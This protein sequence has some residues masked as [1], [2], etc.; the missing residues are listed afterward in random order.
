MSVPGPAAERPQ[1]TRRTL[2][3]AERTLLAWVRTGLAFG[4]VALAVGKI[5]PEVSD[6]SNEWAYAAIGAGYALLGVLVIVYGLVRRNELDDAISEGGY[7][8]VHRAPHHDRARRQRGPRPGDRRRHPL[9]LTRARSC[10]AGIRSRAMTDGSTD[11][12]RARLDALAREVDA[13]EGDVRAAA[14]RL[15]AGIDRLRGSLEELASAPA[16][17]GHEPGADVDGARLTALD[18]VLRGTLARRGGLDPRREVPRCR[19]GPAV[20][21]GLEGLHGV[22]TCPAR[23]RFV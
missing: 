23:R 5:V 2:L 10:G 9:R 22:E 11:E 17:A 7:A 3:A 21:R 20:R 13:L 1:G 6:S 14:E 18:L 8:P 15:R 19:R 16:G 12:A 4:A